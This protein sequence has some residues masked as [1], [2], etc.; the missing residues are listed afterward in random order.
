MRRA[1]AARATREGTQA[2]GSRA[3][4][5]RLVLGAMHEELGR[6]QAAGGVPA[7]AM[8]SLERALAILPPGPSLERARAQ[9]TLAQLRML[10]GAFEASATIAAEV[11]S[12]LEAA[13]GDTPDGRAADAGREALAIR[14][15]ATCTLGVDAA[16]LG[17]LDEGLALLEDATT[18]AREAGR[19]DDLMRAAANRTL[20]LDMDAR[21]EA[22]IAV[23]EASLADAAA[24]GLAAT[25][26]AMLGGN[27]AD[28][29]FQLGRWSEAEAACRAAL[30]WRPRRHEAAW[31]QPLLVLGLVLTE[32][33]ADD[34]AERLVGQT[35]LQLET[36][37]AG[38]WSA[39]VLRT[40]ISLAIWQGDP[41]AALAI[42]EEGWPRVLETEEVTLIAAAASSCLEAAADAAERGRETND[43]GVVARAREHADLVLAEA[44]ARVAA[45]GLDASVGARREADLRIAS[46]R[47]HRARVRGRPSPESWDRQAVAWLEQGAPF[48]EAKARLWQTLAI[49]E[50]TA[51]LDRDTVRAMARGP[52]ADAYR[53][54]L[55]LPSFPLLRVIVDLAKRAR[56]PLPAKD[57]AVVP[58]VVDRGLVA[59]GPG[60]LRLPLGRRTSAR[61]RVGLP[62]ASSSD[63]LP[64][65]EGPAATLDGSTT[66]GGSAT[67]QADG[68][69][70]GPADPVPSDPVARS[71]HELVIASLDQGRHDPYGL[72]PR[73][74][75]VLNILAEGRTDRDIASRLFIS[76]RTVHVHV[77]R[78]LAKLGVGGR[79]EAAGLAI[80]Q[81]LVPE[82]PPPPT[83]RRTGPDD[84]ASVP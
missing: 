12:T 10:E 22:A 41:V 1:I 19:L 6:I 71:I 4:G 30:E 15:H 44:Q 26:G 27:A 67:A 77:R 64:A 55:E 45:W 82:L 66:I 48:A 60:S 17:R 52:L 74:R 34:E 38:Q 36:I 51:D 81:G 46:A 32:S 16:Y 8:S 42:A 63:D 37:P 29:L 21:R 7:E 65:A 35:L 79:T 69:G 39:L 73:E 72:S 5:D 40:A 84:V 11:A 68:G 13:R 50:T 23:V 47:A 59:M 28:I 2:R 56:I 57:P 80:R 18:M 43:A 61:D 70:T 76:E 20:L 33:R 83:V 62:I 78:I 53:L 31:F 25:Y 9:A 3:A 14:G 49:L 24:G 58:I 75:E 54:A